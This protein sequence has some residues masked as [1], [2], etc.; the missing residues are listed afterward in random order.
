MV[1]ECG[2]C[3]KCKRSCNVSLVEKY[4]RLI[5]GVICSL[6]A[7]G[8]VGISLGSVGFGSFN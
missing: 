2:N 3:L 7:L 8:A 1:N 6:L 4:P 5:I